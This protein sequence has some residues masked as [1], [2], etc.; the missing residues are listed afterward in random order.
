MLFQAEK[1]NVTDILTKRK[2]KKKWSFP[3]TLSRQSPLSYRNQS[4]DLVCK[5]K[6]WFPYD[7]GLRHERVK[8]FFS[9]W[10]HLLKKYLM[11]NFI[12]LCSTFVWFEAYQVESFLSWYER[13]INN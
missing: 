11:G 3:L 5:S 4:I 2:K 6:D 1:S 9:K 10:S 8:D 13:D 7:N 12:F